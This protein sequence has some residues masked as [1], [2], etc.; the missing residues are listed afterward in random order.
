MLVLAL[1]ACGSAQTDSSEPAPTEPTPTAEP[2]PDETPPPAP[3]ETGRPSW[4]AEQ[5][6]EH[7]GELVGDIGD[8]AIH[9][10]DYVCATGEP[11]MATVPLGIEG[12][13][14]CPKGA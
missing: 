14:C 13:V 4:T 3:D 9:R 5:C 6:E 11:P 8:G 7:G 2:S 10:P 1:G 12:S